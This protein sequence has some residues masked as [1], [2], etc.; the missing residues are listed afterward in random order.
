MGS[1]KIILTPSEKRQ[2]VV[3]EIFNEFEEM[4]SQLMG[5]F[6]R[7]VKIGERLSYLQ[8]SHEKLGIEKW[9]DWVNSGVLPFNYIQARKYITL[10]EGKHLLPSDCFT[11]GLLDNSEFQ[12]LKSIDDGVSY[13]RNISMSEELED[14]QKAL[15]SKKKVIKGVSWEYVGKS[16]ND[17]ERKI[18]EIQE[19]NQRKIEKLESEYKSKLQG[20]K[21]KEKNLI[22][23]RKQLEKFTKRI[24]QKIQNGEKI[25]S[26]LADNFK[27]FLNQFQ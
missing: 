12:E 5:V 7:A 21:E 26:D 25:D 22:E 27:H 4:S 19:Q 17:S 11:A 8:E 10:Y 6:K 24:Y 3:D 16:L 20:I 14:F 15:K 1:K 2:V 9:K 18:S 13:I 23:Q